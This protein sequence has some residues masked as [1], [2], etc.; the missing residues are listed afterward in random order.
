MKKELIITIIIVIVII[1]AGIA[2][3]NNTKKI[4]GNFSDMLENI[5]HE[6]LQEEKEQSEYNETINN[7]YE[8]WLENDQ[9][10]SIYLEHNE[11]EKITTELREIKGSIEVAQIK[12]SVAHIE[13]CLATLEHLEDKQA[14]N[15]KN[16]F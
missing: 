10:L 4:I 9:G 15:L 16:I 11:L 3:Q 7:I 6:I 5:K 8:Q 2:T 1:V 13:T 12:E 14:F